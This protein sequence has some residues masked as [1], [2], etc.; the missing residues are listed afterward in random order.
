MPFKD[1]LIKCTDSLEKIDGAKILSGMGELLNESQ[2]DWVK[3]NLKNEV[4]FLLRL[5]LEEYKKIP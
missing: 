5:K 3:A 2:K 1:F 4:L